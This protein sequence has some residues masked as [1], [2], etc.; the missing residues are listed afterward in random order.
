MGHQQISVRAR[1]TGWGGN[2]RTAG[3][4]PGRKQAREGCL[5]QLLLAFDDIAD[6]D[7]IHQAAQRLALVQAWI[8]DEAE[9]AAADPIFLEPQPV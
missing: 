4:L 9:R 5:E 1:T 2:G 7:D 8:R 6:R 3:A